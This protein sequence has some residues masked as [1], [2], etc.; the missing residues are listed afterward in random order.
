[1][2]RRPPRSTRTDTLFP[3]TTLFR[4][5]RQVEHHGHVEH[6]VAAEH[7]QLAVREVLHPHDAE[8]QRQAGGHQRVHRA[9]LQPEHQY[10]AETRWLEEQAVIHQI[11]S[12]TISSRRWAISSAGPSYRFSTNARANESAAMP[13]SE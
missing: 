7:E 3:Y 8:D 2:I 13:I 11:H 6:H 1:M 5:P 10:L 9:E 12:F 4:S